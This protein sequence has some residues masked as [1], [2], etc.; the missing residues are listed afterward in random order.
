MKPSKNFISKISILSMAIA[1]ILF[2]VLT[3]I[4]DSFINTNGL[5][6]E[7][8]TNQKSS[9]KIF[10]NE[11]NLEKFQS[12]ELVTSAE[13]IKF[14]PSDHYGLE[15]YTFNNIDEPIWSITNQQ[16]KIK[17]DNTQKN[18]FWN[19]LKHWNVN[20]QDGYI[21][22]YYPE[23][24]IFENISI[25]T[26]SG[27]VNSSNVNANKLKINSTSGSINLNTDNCNTMEASTTSGNVNIEYKSNIIPTTINIEST[28]GD[29]EING[30]Y[31][32]NIKS[33]TISGNIK[34]SG[35]L[36]QNSNFESVSGDIKICCRDDVSNY[37]YN[38]ANISGDIKVDG[39]KFNKSVKSINSNNIRN[40]ITAKTVS[41]DIIVD[42]DK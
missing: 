4:G 21:H 20:N 41:G 16:L 23:N 9:S 26:S 17:I 30:N 40:L 6:I 18:N 22:V 42:F 10:I 37:S 8:S 19:F 15:I 24:A 32:E 5:Q 1:I 11:Q 3:F 12:I 33:K 31:L 7:Y 28:S 34:L 14:I 29:I 35:K 25:D 13:N 27:G 39:K 38:I 36:S 2:G